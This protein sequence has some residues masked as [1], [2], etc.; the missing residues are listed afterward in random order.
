MLG[1][2]ELA[3]TMHCTLLRGC[4]ASKSLYQLFQPGRAPQ[5]EN[6]KKASQNHLVYFGQIEANTGIT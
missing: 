4:F 3:K 5:V 1:L 2:Y 6:T